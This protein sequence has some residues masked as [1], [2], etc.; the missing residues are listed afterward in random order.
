MSQRRQKR[1]S[2]HLTKCWEVTY[3][4]DNQEGALHVDLWISVRLQA[5]E[6]GDDSKQHKLEVREHL[7]MVR[8]SR[9]S[10]RK[11]AA[12]LSK[13]LVFS[14]FSDL[15]ISTSSDDIFKP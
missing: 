13:P 15:V 12:H 10:P 4:G 1:V 2:L 5:G 11:R 7:T 3:F 9:S 6:I 8:P 14:V